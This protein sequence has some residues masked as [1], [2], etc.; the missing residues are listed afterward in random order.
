M[1]K[2]KLLFVGPINSRS[3]YGAHTR[4]LLDSLIEMDKYEIH[5]LQTRWGNTPNNVAKDTYK[6]LYLDRTEQQQF[7]L[8]IQIGIPNEF[9]K[10]TRYD[11]GITAGIETNAISAKWIEGIN[12]IDLVIVPSKFSKEVFME[13]SYVNKR[14]NSTL[15]V[16]TPVEVLF[17]G[18]KSVYTSSTVDPYVRNILNDIKEDFV[19]LFV[20]HWLKGSFGHDRKNVGGMIKIFLEAFRNKPKHLQPALLLKTGVNNSPIEIDKITNQIESIITMVKNSYDKDDTYPQIYLLNGDLTDKQMVSLYNHSKIKAMISFTKGEGYGRPLLEF[21]LTGK[22][23]IASGWS[24]HMD[25]LTKDGS[26]LLP[27]K[28]NTVHPSVV[29]E[30]IIIPNSMWFYV[31]PTVAASTLN[32]VQKDYSKFKGNSKRLAKENKEKFSHKNMTIKF[33]EILDKY[34]P[35]IPKQGTLNLPKLELPKLE[36]VEEK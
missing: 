33:N 23:I 5:I 34:I 19:Y 21:S 26:I 6:D 8:S 28:L 22:P 11:I 27:G 29:W 30:D 2:N 20:G 35:N 1:I 13:T 4:D 12:R 3:G 24:G 16:T 31:S 36:E 15:K 14:D 18:F 9:K 32:I 7:D 10:L 17:E 25:F